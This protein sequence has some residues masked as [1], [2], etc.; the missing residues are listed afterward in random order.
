MP[1]FWPSKLH[2]KKYV[3]TTLIFRPS[4][5]RQKSTWNRRGFFDHRNYIET[6]TWKQLGFFDHRNYVEKVRGIDVDI[7]TIE[8]TSKKFVELTWI[9]RPSKLHRK[10]YME[11][12]WIFRPSKLHQKSTWNR[13]GNS[14]KF[15][16]PR[17]DVIST[18]NPRRFDVVCPLGVPYMLSCLTGLIPY[19]LWCLTCFVPY[20]SHTLRVFVPHLFF[21]LH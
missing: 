21:F 7:S 14:S 6:S 4:K 13:R 10:K 5:L 17:I 2:R 8:I 11:S 3:V 15:G 9:F 20:V 1:I 18:S 12:T 16:L 19:V